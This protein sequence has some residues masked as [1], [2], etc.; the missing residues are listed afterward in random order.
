MNLIL[1]LPPVA[2]TSDNSSIL[3]SRVKPFG[4]ERPAMPRHCSCRLSGISSVAR[5][6]RFGESFETQET[7]APRGPR[8]HARPSLAHP[9]QAPLPPATGAAL[10]ETLVRENP[11]EPCSI[12]DLAI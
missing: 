1:L 7:A 12:N 2:S 11:G 9:P 8:D 10:L 4:V 5:A 3:D 6:T